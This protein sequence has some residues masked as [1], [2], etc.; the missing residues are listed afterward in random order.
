VRRQV[1][2]VLCLSFGCTG[3][4]VFDTAGRVHR[5]R[6]ELNFDLRES[7]LMGVDVEEVYTGWNV[8]EGE[9]CGRGACVGGVGA[10]V[11]GD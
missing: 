1:E 11:E 5:S 6:E 2:G 10:V 9:G 4:N 8:V 3:V 7:I